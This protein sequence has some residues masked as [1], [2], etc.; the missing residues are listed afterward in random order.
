MIGATCGNCGAQW[1]VAW[2]TGMPSLEALK[3][4]NQTAD[5]LGR[6]SFVLSNA[7]A[8]DEFEPVFRCPKCGELNRSEEWRG[9]ITSGAG[10][11]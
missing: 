10:Y 4:V 5:Q 11:N 8:G 6:E 1:V 7:P 2:F 3:V 9:A